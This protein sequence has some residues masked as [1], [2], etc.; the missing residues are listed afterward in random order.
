[1]KIQRVVIL[2]L[3]LTMQSSLVKAQGFDWVYSWNSPFKSPTLFIGG[4][5][6]TGT[7]IE[8]I[9]KNSFSDVVSCCAF[10]DGTGT[11]FRVGFNAE[12]WVLGDYSLQAQVG[13]AFESMES[14]SQSKP[15]TILVLENN[16]HVPKTMNRT[17]IL[18]NSGSNFDIGFIGKRKLFSSHFSIATGF[19]LSMIM[20]E[21][22]E[23]KVMTEY[24]IESSDI[25]SKTY[26]TIV[27]NDNIIRSSVLIR[28]L[29]RCE[30]DLPLARGIYAKPFIQTDYT[31]N[32][33]V[34]NTDP[35]RSLTILGGIAFMFGS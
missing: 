29:I 10:N 7:S 12:Y 15:S 5:I 35:W 6:G 3:I 28:P 32:P 25:E 31:I 13:Y 1:M 17:Y 33:R 34:T 18:S 11:A 24:S 26:P 2:L 21:S 22:N 14:R 8:T 27:P 23:T 9:G 30:Y 19:S 16:R 4:Y 20:P